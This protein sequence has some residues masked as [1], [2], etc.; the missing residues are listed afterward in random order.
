[1]I[2]K[3]INQSEKYKQECPSLNFFYQFC[4]LSSKYHFERTILFCSGIEG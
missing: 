3:M 2:I 1:M 4:L